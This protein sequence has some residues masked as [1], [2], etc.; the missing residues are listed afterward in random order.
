M[1]IV[2]WRYCCECAYM[3]DTSQDLLDASISFLIVVKLPHVRTHQEM[4]QFYALEHIIVLSL[5]FS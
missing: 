1:T 3:S 4:Q 2:L 5:L